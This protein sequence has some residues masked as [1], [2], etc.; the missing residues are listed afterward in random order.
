ML[1]VAVHLKTVSFVVDMH[2]N[3]NEYIPYKLPKYVYMFNYIIQSRTL[4]EVLK[5]IFE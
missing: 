2:Y 4:C 1:Y 5:V 3:W